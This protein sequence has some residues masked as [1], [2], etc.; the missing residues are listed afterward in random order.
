VPY[1]KCE[2]RTKRKLLGGRAAINFMWRLAHSAKEMKARGEHGKV[3]YRK[4]RDRG[5]AHCEGLSSLRIFGSLSRSGETARFRRDSDS[6]AGFRWGGGDRRSVKK[7][8]FGRRVRENTFIRA[9]GKDR[10]GK[11]VTCDGR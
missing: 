7:K 10:S 8:P 11:Q 1:K 6:S 9:R 4:G 2:E 5:A 3:A